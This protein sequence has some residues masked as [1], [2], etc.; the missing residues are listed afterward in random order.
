MFIVSK[1]ELAQ[2]PFAV[3]VARAPGTKCQRCWVYAEDVGA[4]PAHPPVC[5]KCAA[6]LR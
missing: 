6:A 2:G 5:G 3:E 1:V 4:D